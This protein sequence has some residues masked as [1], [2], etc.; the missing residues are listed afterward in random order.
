MDRRSYDFQISIK[1]LKNYIFDFDGTLGDSKEGIISSFRK[2]CKNTNITPLL[3]LNDKNLIGPSL[4]QLVIDIAGPE[5]TKKKRDLLRLEFI[6]IYD[7]IDYKKTAPYLNLESVL[8]KLKLN[9]KKLYIV[10]N[11]RE[12]ITKKILNHFGWTDLF[13]EVYGSD[14]YSSGHTKSELINLLVENLSI[15]R[16]ETCYI[17]DKFEDEIASLENNLKFFY[18]SWNEDCDGKGLSSPNELLIT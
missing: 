12:K 10:T 3:S 16:S 17:G 5:T 8:K 14:T 18:A 2:A 11:K 15:E 1:N 4:D 6:K 7:E 13:L 9:N